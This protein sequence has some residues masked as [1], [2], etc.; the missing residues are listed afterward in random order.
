LLTDET[1]LQVYFL[2]F[3]LSPSSVSYSSIVSSQKIA[4]ELWLQLDPRYLDDVIEETEWEMISKREA[5]RKEEEEGKSNNSFLSSS[6]LRTL[7]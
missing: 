2:A 4:G 6:F 7:L 1:L 5:A 3:L